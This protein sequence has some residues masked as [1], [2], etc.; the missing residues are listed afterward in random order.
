MGI[1]NVLVTRLGK[2]E[3]LTY[4]E[5]DRNIEALKAI[6]NLFVASSKPPI[7]SYALESVLMPVE[8]YDSTGEYTLN[9]QEAGIYS[10]KF[11][12]GAVNSN[13]TVNAAC[14]ILDANYN[15]VDSFYPDE[16]NTSYS[17]TIEEPIIVLVGTDALG[18]AS[19]VNLA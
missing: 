15:V 13:V 9:A 1:E 11:T 4:E 7:F 12:D 3:P 16:N 14:S 18:Y 19:G 8:K 17:F 2:G 6:F 5:M 10:V